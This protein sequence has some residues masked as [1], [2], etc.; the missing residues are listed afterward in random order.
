MK[1]LEDCGRVAYGSHVTLRRAAE[2]VAGVAGV[3]TCGS[4]W[5]CSVC[6][7]KIAGQRQDELRRG[8]NNWWGAGGHVLMMTLTMRHEAGDP[9]S[10]LW[11]QLGRAW[12]S[13]TSGRQWLKNR[14]QYGIQGYM[15]VV[16]QTHGSNGWHVHIH[17]LLFLTEDVSPLELQTL[18]QQMVARWIGKL[19]RMGASATPAGQRLERVGEGDDVLA[20]YFTKA[21]DNGDAIA[22]ELNWG[23]S[24]RARKE[25]SRAPF[26]ILDDFIATGDAEDLELW[27][28]FA[29]A[30]KGRRQM[31]WGA[32][33]R[34]LL[35]LGAEMTD[36]EIA[37]EEI[38]TEEDDM[39]AI[40]ADEWFRLSRD[41]GVIAAVLHELELGGVDACELLLWELGYSCERVGPATG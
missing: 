34:D 3:H 25:G 5:V 20:D 7:A 15:R 19:E 30:S 17:A 12:A 2:G 6:S 26:G 31:T 35:Q 33:T 9:L 21:V 22:L 4:V 38:G 24:K 32:G 1:R 14:A 8:L 16:E 40:P 23:Q 18:E 36:E 27:Q 11:D 29:F 13:V 39:L 37:D 10:G 41:G 28:E